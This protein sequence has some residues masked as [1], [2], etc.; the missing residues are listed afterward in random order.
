MLDRLKAELLKR[1]GNSI[2]GSASEMPS[3]FVSIMLQQIDQNYNLELSLIACA[4]SLWCGADEYT[5]MPVA[6]GAL[7]LRAG[8]SAHIGLCEFGDELS[9]YDSLKGYEDAEIILA[10]DG[11]I[12]LAMQYLSE[13]GGR[14][15]ARITAEAVKAAGAGGTLSGLSVALDRKHGIRTAVPDGRAAFELYNGQ[16]ARFT[17]HCGAMLAGASDLMLDDAAQIGLLTG[18]A[19]FLSKRSVTERDAGKKEKLLFQARSLI[20]EAESITGTKNNASLF[21]TLLYLSDFF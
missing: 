12:A 16:L 15:S 8:I 9:V 10:G 17:S 3:E 19:L 18:R 6:V 13:N 11:L 5:G 2:A 7:F 4:S 21:N 20:Q 1:A 14:H